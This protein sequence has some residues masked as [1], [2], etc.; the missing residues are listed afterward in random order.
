[1]VQLILVITEL[2]EIICIFIS[3]CSFNENCKKCVFSQFSVKKLLLN[4][5]IV[6]F[7]PELILVL[8]SS[9][10]MFD[11]IMLISSVNNIGLA[12][13]FMVNGKSFI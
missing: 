4:Q 13:L 12:I 8:N 2:E 9:G 7:K 10:L 5:L 3:L 1:L 6:S 11:I